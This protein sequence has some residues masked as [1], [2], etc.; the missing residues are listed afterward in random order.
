[1]TDLAMVLEVFAAFLGS[2]GRV[3]DRFFTSLPPIVTSCFT[4]LIT[5]FSVLLGVPALQ[6]H[7]A[8]MARAASAWENFIVFSFLMRNYLNSW[9]VLL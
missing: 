5:L 6:P 1:M 8:I 2:V 7:I 9:N 4:S 3:G